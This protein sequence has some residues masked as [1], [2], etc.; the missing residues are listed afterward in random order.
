MPKGISKLL[1]LQ[2]LRSYPYFLSLSMEEDGV[3]RLEDVGKMTEIEEIAFKIED[4]SQLKRMEEG[5]LEPMLKMRRLEVKNKIDG[6]QFPN[7]PQF[8]ETMSAMTD[9][10]H[11]SLTKFAVPS[12]I[13]C[14]ANLRLLYLGDCHCSNYTELQAIPNLVSLV[15]WGNKICKKFPNGFGKSGGFPHLHFLWIL[16]FPELEEFPEM[17]DRAMACLEKLGLSQCRKV[18]KVGEGLERLKS[19][20][21]I[22]F[23]YSG[24]NEL[25]EMLKEGGIYWKIIKAINPQITVLVRE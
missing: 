20:K 11:L 12:W 4:E 3:L 13:C 8:P 2:T 10:E 23:K 22:S 1:S 16:G 14:L 17:E 19:L 25:R 21:D 5:I 24:T 9:L 6:M 15:L 18:N 7:L